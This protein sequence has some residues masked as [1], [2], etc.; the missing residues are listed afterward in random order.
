MNSIETILQNLNSVELDQSRFD[1]VGSINRQ[2]I[3]SAILD[4]TLSNGKT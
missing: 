2:S 3:E 4:Y 1:R